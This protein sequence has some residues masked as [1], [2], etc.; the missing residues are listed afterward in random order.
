MFHAHKLWIKESVQTK[1][2]FCRECKGELKN[3]I[4]E[5]SSADR[6]GFNKLSEV[7]VCKRFCRVVIK[8]TR[9][10]S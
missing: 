7:T 9:S 4:P 6:M 3:H 5:T 8:Q 2:L 10:T 1:L